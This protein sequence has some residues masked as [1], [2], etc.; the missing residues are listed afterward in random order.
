M[1]VKM[2]MSWT[3]DGHK[4]NLKRRKKKKKTKRKTRKS[5]N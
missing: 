3:T 1:I 5:I 4:N 2:R